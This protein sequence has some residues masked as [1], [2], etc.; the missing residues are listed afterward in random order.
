MLDADLVAADDHVVVLTGR[1][2]S[3]QPVQHPEVLV[4]Q[5][6][7]H[8]LVELDVARLYGVIG[9][10]L[11]GHPA[12]AHDAAAGVALGGREDVDDLGADGLMAKVRFGKIQ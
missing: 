9:G 7:V 5:G 3:P 12:V 11:G 6:G 10:R 8:G 1:A 2:A 4:A